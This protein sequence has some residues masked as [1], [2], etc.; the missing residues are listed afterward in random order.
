MKFSTHTGLVIEN[1]DGI[2][3]I[4]SPHEMERAKVLFEGDEVGCQRE[5]DK[6]VSHYTERAKVEVA[7]A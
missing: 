2:V 5:Y 6:W 1:E 7:S 4:Y 3:R